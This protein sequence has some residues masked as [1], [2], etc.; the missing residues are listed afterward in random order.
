MQKRNKAYI[1]CR[2]LSISEFG[3]N[4]KPDYRVTQ[5]YFTLKLSSMVADGKIADYT[6]VI[7]P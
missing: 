2:L 5:S 4:K 6:A 1:G 7:Q 3:D